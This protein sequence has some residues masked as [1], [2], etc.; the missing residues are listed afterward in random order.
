MVAISNKPSAEDVQ[1][2]PQ[3]MAQALD[4]A[5]RWILNAVKRECNDSDLR[6]I[7]TSLQVPLI[8]R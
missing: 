2:T 1:T 3:E 7:G 8:A 4:S 6:N 5:A